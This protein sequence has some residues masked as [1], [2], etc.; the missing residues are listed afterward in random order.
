L[1]QLL[2]AYLRRD[3]DA[4]P[5]WRMA[6][7]PVDELRAPARA[8]GVGEPIDTMAVAGG[9]TLPGVEI[10]SAGIALAG[11]RTAALRDAS[12]PVIGR[13]QEDT[14]ILDLRTVAPADDK[15]LAR[16]VS[17]VLGRDRTV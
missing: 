16:T 1:Q 11:D 8:L 15:H 6:A 9:G 3:G 10:P 12:P 14:T 7:L 2:L 4:I 5:F 13:V 17:A